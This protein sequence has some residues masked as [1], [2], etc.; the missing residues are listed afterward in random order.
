MLSQFQLLT[1]LYPSYFT[2]IEFTMQE[3]YLDPPPLM[4]TNWKLTI[5]MHSLLSQWS[6]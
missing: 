1:K 5:F 2:T 3:I 6:N 4:D